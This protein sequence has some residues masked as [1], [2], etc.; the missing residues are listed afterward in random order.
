M[1]TSGGSSAVSNQPRGLAFDDG[2]GTLYVADS[3]TARSSVQPKKPLGPP[4]SEK[5]KTRPKKNNPF[6]GPQR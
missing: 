3:T 1:D 4:L 2:D 5:K 6:D